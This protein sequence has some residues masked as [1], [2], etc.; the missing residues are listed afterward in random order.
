MED[1]ITDKS[2]LKRNYKWLVPSVVVV[3]GVIALLSFSGDGLAGFARAYSDKALYNGALALA[4]KDAGAKDL[5]GTLEP[6][7]NLALMESSI[8]YADNEQSV[9]FTV[10]VKGSKGKGRMDVAAT[11]VAGAW[12]YSA[13]KIR[14]KNPQGE[15]LILPN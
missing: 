5:L 7:D 10:R 4:K 3:M 14:S 11:K 8:D 13:I 1:I 2:W 15:A 9:V 12:H 6:Y